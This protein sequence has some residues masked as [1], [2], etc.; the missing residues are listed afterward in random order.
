[1][2][3]VLVAAA[4]F[5]AFADAPAKT[6]K[7]KIESLIKH[8]EGLKDATFIRNGVSYDA[9][10]AAAFLRGKWDANAKV[11]NTAKDFIDKAASQSSTSGKPYLIRFKDGKE[12]KSGDYLLSELK[13]LEDLKPE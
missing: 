1:M 4:M 9:K 8:V 10:A 6:E 3:A 12:V 13:K 5:P 2:C 7:E 11:I